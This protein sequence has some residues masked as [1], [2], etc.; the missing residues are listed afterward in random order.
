MKKTLDSIREESGAI[1]PWMARTRLLLEDE[2]MERI[3][4][5][6]VLVVGLGGV[7]AICAEMIARA[8]VGEMTI[9]DADVVEE[10]N[11]N[12]Q[13]VALTSTEGLLKSEVL[14]Q[15]LKDINP[16][17]KLN[18]LPMYFYHKDRENVLNTASFTYAVDCI[19]TLS[20]KVYFIQSCL[21][22]GIPLVSSM[23]AGGKF[24][25]TKVKV[26][27]IS[28]TYQCHLARYVRKKLH[29]KGVYRGFKAVFSPEIADPHKV[30]PTLGEEKKKS[31]IG[32]ISYIPAVF[33]CVCASVAIREVAGIPISLHS[34]D[35]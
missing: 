5:A 9:I 18:A 27:D 7:G 3:T 29:T 4:K 10:T 33:G 20:P 16:E 6:H 34:S 22:R 21:E 11:K 14:A 12:R 26:A 32:T 30:I 8:G 35:I 17:L 19:D 31:V 15:R 13:L 23:G 2:Q 1:K 24:D 25:P 28:E